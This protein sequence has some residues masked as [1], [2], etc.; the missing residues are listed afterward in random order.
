MSHMFE[1]GW[2][3]ADFWGEQVERDKCIGGK[4]A[5]VFLSCGSKYVFHIKQIINVISFTESRGDI[6]R[7][8]GG[9]NTRN[10]Y[11]KPL[12]DFNYVPPKN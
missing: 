1:R 11:P 9:E 5:S 7:A 8:T 2:E 3:A 12:V 6:L 10:F 4:V